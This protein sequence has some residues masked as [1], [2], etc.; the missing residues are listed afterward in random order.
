MNKKTYINPELET[1]ELQMNQHLL[2]GS[3]TV[4]VEPG[5]QPPSSTDAPGFVDI[6]ELD[7]FKNM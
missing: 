2:D 7:I 3:I 4:D 6:D 1:F 5:T